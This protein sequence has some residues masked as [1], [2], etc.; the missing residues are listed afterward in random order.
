MNE[1]GRIPRQIV[2]EIR[3]ET[4]EKL[5]SAASVWE[6]EIKRAAGRLSL[7]RSLAQSAAS[8]GFK[9]LPVRFEHAVAASAL[10]RL[11]GDLFDRML[12]AQARLEGLT[13]VSADRAVGRYDVPLLSIE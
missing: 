6:V 3:S 2:D 4:N 5:V 8:A 7:P 10:P 12:V 13:L 11:H 1:P 9:E